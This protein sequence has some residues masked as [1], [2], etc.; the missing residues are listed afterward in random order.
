MG[1]PSNFLQL[2]E[3]V[4]GSTV[5]KSALEVTHEMTKLVKI[6]PRC[7]EHFQELKK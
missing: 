1:I 4:K 3:A 2:G 5:M 6:S 7:D